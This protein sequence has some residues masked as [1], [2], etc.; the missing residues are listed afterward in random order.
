MFDCIVIGGGLIGLLSAHELA[1]A[2]LRV[3]LLDQSATG[4]AASWAGGGILSPLYPWRYAP[5]I[6]ALA[7]WS[8]AA[9]PGLA[10]QLFADTGINAEWLQSG[11]LLL[12][13]SDADAARAWQATSGHPLRW[14]ESE[15]LHAC[16]P[17][18]ADSFE[19]AWWM[20]EVAQIRN[21]RLLKALHKSLLAHGCTIEENRAITGLQ[22]RQ[23]RLAGITT[24]TGH[25]QAEKIVLAAGAWSAQLL[26]TQGLTLPVR[27]V[28]GQMLLLRGPA[29]TLSHIVLGKGRYLV[30][31]ADGRV[32]VGST[33]EEAGFD[34]QATAGAREELL[35]AAH[36]LVPVLSTFTL[37]RHWAGLRPGSPEG[38]PYIGEHPAL[39]G[40]FLNT[41]HHRNGI[42]MAPASARLLADQLLGRDPVLDPAPYQPG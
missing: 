40:L 13:T 17:G 26:A 14:L 23:G 9:Y 15:A 25:L 18:L 19:A 7:D 33:M 35:A 24:A 36:E 12:D 34:N 16:E 3:C 41:G 21:P 22:I 39:P 28:R 1:T 37:E 10:R 38:V 30:P 42:V 29:G 31:R 6:Q 5:D 11:L 8:Q 4:K 32:L 2:G 20:P 27:P